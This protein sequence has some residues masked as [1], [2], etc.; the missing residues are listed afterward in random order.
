MEEIALVDHRRKLRPLIALVV[1]LAGLIGGAARAADAPAASAILQDLQSFREMGS[2]LYVAAHPDDENTQLITYLAR[3]R[4]YRTAYLSLTRGDGG[5]NVL[6]PE[7][8]EQLGVIR[9]QE[10]LAARRVDGGRQFFSHALDFGFSKTP[11][12]TLRIWDRQQVLADVVRVIRTFRPDVVIARFS[13]TAG[14]T[15]GHH[16]ASAILAVEAFKLCG[17][18]KA[19]PDQ[20]TDLAPWQPKRILLNGRGGGSVVLDIGGNDPVSGEPFGKLAARSRSMHKTQGFGNFVGGGGG[21]AGARA[22]F[23]L[24]AGEP[25]TKDILDGVD[26][27][28][29][30]VPG[31]A[32]IGTLADDTIVH[33]DPRHPSASL[34]A[35]LTLR[36]RLAALHGD[37]PVDEKRELLDR[38]VAA[39]LGLTVQTTIAQAEIVPGESLKMEHTVTL[40][41]DTPVRWTAVRYPTIAAQAA[42]A[43][44]LQSDTPVMRDATQTLPASTP[45]SQPYWLR[46]DGTAGMFRVDDPKLIG[47]PENPPAFPIEFVFDVGGQTLVVPDEP[48]AIG[49]DAKKVQTPRR[50]E[51]IPPVSLSFASQVQLFAPGASHPVIVEIAASRAGVSGALRLESSEGWKVEPASLPFQ[52]SGI[53]DR[54]KLTFNVTA[55]P[56]LTTATLTARAQVGDATFDNQRIE[57]QFEHIPP[58]LLQPRARLKAVCLDLA[59]RGKKIGYIP[60]AGDSV[61]ECLTQM[62]YEVTQLAGADLTPEKLKT[63][64]AIVTGVRAFNVRTDLSEQMPA[65]FA[66]VEAGGNVIEQYNRPDGLKTSK[67]APYD[68][69]LSGDRVTDEEAAMTF[70]APE[71]P[72]LNTPNKMA[73]ADF[74]GW[75]QERG[76]YFPNQWDE[77]W[78]A[79]LACNDPGEASKKGSLLIAPHGKGYFVYTGL[80]FF[81]ELPAGVPGAYRLFANLVSLGK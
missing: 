77:H 58:I 72:A 70:L 65:L 32:E 81:R 69:H 2:A 34:P 8:G 19:F 49:V 16:T 67:I 64:D 11:D 73:P 21:G 3:G 57:I 79:I 9:T 22:D 14:N 29:A 76:I 75:V 61:P 28:W 71:H 60:G 43:G 55:P 80:V 42:G 53:D 24:L 52:L 31:G 13:P 50:M 18:P 30:R 23:T 17:D 37:P 15:H 1:A 46:E 38:I 51:V 45:P 56:K 78:T 12:E 6:G 7:F 44:A 74:D 20:L 48:V 33:F 35:L 62:G 5:Q 68:L 59:T 63:F 40:H 4:H 10:L 66:Y 36:Q 25:M 54:A 39:C 27:T 47:R 41:S 26:T